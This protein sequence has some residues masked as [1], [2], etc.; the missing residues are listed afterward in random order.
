M[1]TVDVDIDFEH[2]EC[3]ARDGRDGVGR[4]EGARPGPR[5]RPIRDQP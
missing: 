1:T 2:G 3:V 5:H 4:A